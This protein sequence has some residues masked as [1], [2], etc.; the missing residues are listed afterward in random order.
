L[1]TIMDAKLNDIS[2]TA[3]AYSDSYLGRVATFGGR[4]EPAWDVDALTIN[5]YLGTD[6][7]LPFVEDCRA[8]GKGVFVLLR[9]SNPSAGELQDLPLR[10]DPE[11]NPANHA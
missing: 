11:R 6:G 7:L 9:T 1:I 2:S 8:Y 10:A 3:R 4:E 5:P